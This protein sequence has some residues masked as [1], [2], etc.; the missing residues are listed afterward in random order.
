MTREEAINDL[1]DFIDTYLTCHGEEDT[2]AV[3]LDNVDVEALDMAIKALEQNESAEEWYKL[4]VEK[5]EQEPSGDLISRQAVIDACEQ[6]INIL[7]AVDRI[8]DLPSVEQEPKYCD[9][10]ICIQNEYNGI[11][12][13]ECNVSNGDVKRNPDVVRLCSDIGILEYVR[14]EPPTGHW[15]KSNIPNEKYV[16]SEC[17][18]GCWYYDYQADVAKSRYC[19]NCGAKMESEDKE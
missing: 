12:C 18:G 6:S 11:G 13:D 9:R 5:L 14:Q 19:P 15:I 3:S 16:C 17:G 4:F 1:K 8:M 7:E 10:N 2:I